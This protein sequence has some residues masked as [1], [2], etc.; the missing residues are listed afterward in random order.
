[1]T[2]N[3]ID[4]TDI[5]A[6][7]PIEEDAVVTIDDV[8]EE[9]VDAVES[10][11]APVKAEAKVKP[12]PTAPASVES[13]E[14]KVQIILAAI[15]QNPIRKRFS[16][17]VDALQRRL[18]SLG[19]NHVVADKPGI[20]GVGTRLAVQEFQRNRRLE[21]TETIDAVTL[22]AIFKGDSSVEVHA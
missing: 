1:M 22:K 2:D 21:E 17:S 8:A 7:D 6:V 20:L 19:F 4:P 3:N 9:Q 12:A 18:A 5:D 10:K 14:P 15:Q 16:T 13:P 11:P